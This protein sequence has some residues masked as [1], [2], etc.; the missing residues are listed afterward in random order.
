MGMRGVKRRNTNHWEGFTGLLR[1]GSSRSQIR[2]ENF[3]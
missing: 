2:I 3:M 1:K